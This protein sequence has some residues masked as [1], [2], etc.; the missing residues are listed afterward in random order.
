LRSVRSV[1]AITVLAALAAACGEDGSSFPASGDIISTTPWN[2]PESATY[3]L[4]DGDDVVGSGVLSIGR[5]GDALVLRQAF[6]IPGEEI[7]DD[8]TVMADPA[9]LRP[10][11][12]ARAITGP[13]GQRRCLATYSD[14]DVTVEQE[15]VQGQRTDEL[16]LPAAAYDTW[17]DLFLWRTLAFGQDLELG[18]RDVLTCSLARPEVLSVV[19]KIKRIED[20]SV[21]AGD[22]RAWRLEVRSGGRTQKVWYADDPARTLVR[23]D[24]GDLVFE[25]ESSD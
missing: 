5:D 22:F 25:L 17:A 4:L 24:N 1:A 11:L 8:V 23:Y 19:L 7:T 21:P 12:V 2:V 18:Y 15:S 6:E 13:E 14:T 10:S 3:R 20:V 16:E 9:T